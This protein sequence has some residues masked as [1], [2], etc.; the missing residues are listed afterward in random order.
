MSTS[1]SLSTTAFFLKGKKIYLSA[2]C[3]GS[4]QVSMSSQHIISPLIVIANISFTSDLVLLLCVAIIQEDERLAQAGQHPCRRRQRHTN[5]AHPSSTH[6]AGGSAGASCA[7]SRPAT[8]DRHHRQHERRRQQSSRAGDRHNDSGRGRGKCPA[9][10]RALQHRWRQGQYWL[11]AVL[12]PPLPCMPMLAPIATP[13]FPCHAMQ[14]YCPPAACAP[15]TCPTAL[16]GQTVGADTS[17]PR[18]AGRRAH[19]PRVRAARTWVERACGQA[20]GSA[21]DVRH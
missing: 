4:T 12:G 18:A 3:G 8:N 11:T 17:A 14:F 2:A 20:A 7:C 13:A 9:A 10:V 21:K 5:A 6:Q 16:R 1:H 15:Q 19:H